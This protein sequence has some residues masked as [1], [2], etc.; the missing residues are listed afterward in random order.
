VSALAL[1]AV[2]SASA[3]TP[4]QIVAKLDAQR[5]ANGIP[6]GIKL[7]P[8]GSQGCAA[9]LRYE[10]LNGIT[11]SHTE[12]PGKPGYSKAGQAAASEADL[13]D[14]GGWESGDPFE[15]LPL[16]LS[17]L[18]EPR[19]ATIG[20][21]ELGARTCV[22]LTLGYTRTFAADKV[23][24]YPG[25]GGRVPTSET[26]HGEQ[27][28]A[29]GDLVGLPQGRTTG[30]TIYVFAV[31]PWVATAPLAVTSAHVTGPGGPVELKIVDL[32]KFP[33]LTTYAPSGSAFLIP[34]S[35]LRPGRYSASVTLAAGG[36]T[37]SRRWQFTA[38]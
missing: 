11:F 31:G 10:Q 20:A 15:S 17:N 9:H 27:P 25:P 14:A 29:P 35:P 5:V 33:E 32:H 16:H 3:E 37:M 21:A 36:T 1:V 12:S 7:D 23:F 8:A 26:V 30:P 13:A 4:A 18:L 24:T 19:L 38:G 2:T 6:G 22:T 28:F 34:V